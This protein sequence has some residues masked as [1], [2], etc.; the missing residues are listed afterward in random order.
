MRLKSYFAASVEAA[1]SQAGQELGAEALLVNSRRTAPE[2]R[3]LG[4]YEVIFAAAEPAAAAL[5]PA[6]PAPAPQRWDHLTREVSELRRQIERTATTLARAAALAAG[7]APG[8]PGFAEAAADLIASE[9]AA[10][11]ARE[12]VEGARQRWLG[13]RPP[14]EA[15]PAG[16]VPP[17][18][19]G[20]RMRAALAAEIAGR[21]E[22]DA[23]LGRTDSARRVVA[24]VGPP[25][26]GKT[27]LLVKLAATYGLAARGPAQILSVDT[28][29]I[30]AAEQLRVFANILGIGFQVL[31]TTGALAQAVEEH[32]HKELI[33]ND[34]P[35]FGPQDLDNGLD[36]ALFLATHQ[37][38]DT[39]L[40]LSATT[41]SADLTRA[42]DRFDIFQPAKLAFTRVDE[43]G[44]FGPL[45]NLAERT[46][47]PVSFL[48]AGQRIPEDLEPADRGRI[49][50]LLLGRE[51]AGARA[52]A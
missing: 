3:H 11:L 39:H 16:R 6:G 9:V 51:A 14:G 29:R 32:R 35:G 38:M 37:E 24:L 36:L 34:T 18:A 17:P 46:G 42:V 50:D 52:A 26:A 28:A 12:I 41:R 44:A 40:V 30:A 31:E 4:E 48:T 49:V 33:L 25:G 23:T 27:T 5:P 2:T 7:G 20:D 10:D 22:V 15:R 1:V 43:A 47:K 21:I 19:D 13:Q 8:A 45:L